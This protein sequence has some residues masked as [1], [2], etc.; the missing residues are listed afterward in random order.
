MLL[1]GV[2]QDLLEICTRVLQ[3]HNLQLS[4]NA[5]TSLQQQQQQQ[6][7]LQGISTAGVADVEG[8]SKGARSAAVLSK[9]RR[10]YL[11]SAYLQGAAL[12]TSEAASHSVASAR[13]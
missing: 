3:Q 12:P 8:H 7:Q 2:T 9:A 6:Q 4:T 13:R 10:P 11:P 5:G 1:G